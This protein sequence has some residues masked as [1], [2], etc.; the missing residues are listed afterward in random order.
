MSSGVDHTTSVVHVVDRLTGGV[1]VAVCDYI[2][3]TPQE[4][5]H[6]IVSPWVDGHPSEI[7]SGV[8]ADH[9]DLGV[10]R[11]RQPFR[12]R[13]VLRAV[14]ADV[15]HAHSS[16]PGAFVRLVR[17]RG[18]PVIY[19]PHCFKFD[20]PGVSK[21]LRLTIRGVERFLAR[22]T[23]VFAVL[24]G[25]EADLAR[26]L[27]AEARVARVPNTA[28]VSPRHSEPRP[29]GAARR[30]GMVGRLAGQKDPG[31]MIELATELRAD[32]EP[33]ETVW[34]GGGDASWTARLEAAGVRVTGWLT[35]DDVVRE[36]DALSLYVHTAS[37]EGF[38]LSV[39]DAAARGI[40]VLGRRIPSLTEVGLATFDSA[41]EGAAAV[42]RILDDPDALAE[43]RSRGDR[44]LSQMNETTQMA[45]LEAIW[46]HPERLHPSQRGVND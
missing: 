25:H 35:K 45:A 6:T 44:M 4:I 8:E 10:S 37:Y 3:H 32:P 38:P 17:P 29:N 43:T 30:I 18:T 9:V 19:S 1:P 7:W 46:L 28:S 14:D 21:P 41:R 22:R 26:G 42:R 39:L 23:D 40:P 20:D 2:R 15:I 11:L 27:G 16:F 33:V 36:L 24:S 12:T 34:I 5:R 13:E 31:M